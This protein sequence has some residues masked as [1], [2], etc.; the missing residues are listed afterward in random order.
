MKGSVVAALLLAAWVAAAGS[1]VAA[2]PQGDTWDSIKQLPDWSGVFSLDR[3]GHETAGLDSGPDDHGVVP[4]TPEYRQLRAQASQGK[5]QPNLAYCLPAGVPGVMLHTLLSEWLFTPGRVTVLFEDGELRR[6]YTD[7]STH[8]PLDEMSGSYMG[9]SIGHWEG[10][11][12]VVDTIGFPKGELFANG[13]L[14]ANK[15]THYVERIFLKD[16]NHLQIDSAL[17]DPKVFT[18]PYV[19][20]RI[21]QREEDTAM[22]E[23]MCAQS[24]R[25]HGNGIDLTPPSD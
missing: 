1:A 10:N 12:L 11:V 9:D 7:R 2:S 13:G 21:M 5:G 22:P 19:V 8:L 18:K 17:D 3:T 6:I 25:D 20:T 15:H 24:A 23:P 4:L 14:R 16:K